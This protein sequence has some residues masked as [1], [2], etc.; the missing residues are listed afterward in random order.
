MALEVADRWI[1]METGVVIDQGEV[2]ANTFE[3]VSRRLA[4]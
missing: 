2:T 4:V 3:T 1:V